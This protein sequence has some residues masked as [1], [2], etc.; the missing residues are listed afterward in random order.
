MTP[1]PLQQA[2]EFVT[3]RE[4]IRANAKERKRR[5]RERQAERARVSAALLAEQEEALA[6]FLA[7]KVL[8]HPIIAQDGRMIV[9]PRI[10]IVGR[11]AMRHDPIA[12]MKLP[13]RHKAA[14][15]RIRA[16]WFTVGTG[17]S[18]GAM[19]YLRSGGG[20]GDGPAGHAAML[21]Q[22]AAR[23]RLEGAWA[24]LGTFT[25]VV[26]R[27]VLDGIPVPVYAREIDRGED[28][29]FATLRLAL[30]RL[31]LFYWPEPIEMAGEVP[32]LTFGPARASYEVEIGVDV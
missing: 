32:I 20:S 5:Q 9:G 31:A 28:V 30:A 13:S 29:L 11:Q 1:T 12:S 22:I 3:A 19:D 21:D 2:V 15:K 17:C 24:F 26:A 8:R 18:V 10:T 16:D 7:P 25:P 14:A 4:R 27:V 23:T 6:E